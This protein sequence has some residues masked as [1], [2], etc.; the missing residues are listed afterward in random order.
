MKTLLSNRVCIPVVQ[1]LDDGGFFRLGGLAGTNLVQSPSCSRRFRRPQGKGAH[2]GSSA[3]IDTKTSA[4][5][6]VAIGGLLALLVSLGAGVGQA[7]AGGTP[8][9]TLDDM[10]KKS[11]A[12]SFKGTKSATGYR[13]Y[14]SMKSPHKKVSN[15]KSSNKKVATVAADSF[16]AGGKTYYSLSVTIKKRGTTTIS[17]KWGKKNYKVKYMVKKYANP[18]KAFKVGGKDY[19]KLFAPSKQTYDSD[20][21]SGAAAASKFTG[22]LQITPAKGWKVRGI[23]CYD[24]S[25]KMKTVKNGASIKNIKTIWVTMTKGRQYERLYLWAGGKL[26]AAA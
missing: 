4:F 22:K 26:L 5:I 8:P 17:F 1:R 15:A 21:A 9:I 16:T 23:Y 20:A 11:F 7:W 2:M 13:S 3:H 14:S 10:A 18:V 24:A 25:S 12:T 19:A 6:A